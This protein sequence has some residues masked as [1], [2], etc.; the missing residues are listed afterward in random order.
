MSPTIGVGDRTRYWREGLGRLLFAYVARDRRVAGD[1]HN[2]AAGAQSHAAVAG[3]LQRCGGAEVVLVRPRH[4]GWHGP[5]G[6][7]VPVNERFA[8]IVDVVVLIEGEE[9]EFPAVW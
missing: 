6:C 2:V 8:V 3:D 5:D 4:A 1:D 9:T 7:G